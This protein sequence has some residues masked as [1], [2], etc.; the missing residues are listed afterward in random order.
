METYATHSLK[1][2][3]R[4][5]HLVFQP[6]NLAILLWFSYHLMLQVWYN[7]WTK[8]YLLHLV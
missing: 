7:L 6:Y 4:V 3:G 1:H 5:Y 2:V 8:E